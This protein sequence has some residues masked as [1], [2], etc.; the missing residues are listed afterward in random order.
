MEKYDD[1]IKRDQPIKSKNSVTVIQNEISLFPKDSKLRKIW[2]P[3]ISRKDFTPTASHRVCSLHLPGE[4]ETYLNVSTVVPK[5]VK[6][7]E[8]TPRRTLNSIGVLGG[9]AKCNESR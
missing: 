1:Q 2:L 4:K 9:F 7:I 3:V 5:T 6:P 8:S